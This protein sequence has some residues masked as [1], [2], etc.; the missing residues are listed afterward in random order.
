MPTRTV[1]DEKD[2]HKIRLQIGAEVSSFPDFLQ[3]THDA[4]AK[5]HDLHGVGYVK[6][7]WLYLPIC[8]EEGGPL[9]IVDPS[10]KIVNRLSSPP[11]KCAAT[12]LE[13]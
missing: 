9:N 10:G 5:L 13:M 3:G 12:E 11:Y 6:A 1:R 2:W 4:L 8:T 7:G